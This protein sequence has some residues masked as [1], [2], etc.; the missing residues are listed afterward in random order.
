MENH[1]VFPFIYIDFSVNS[2]LYSGYIVIDLPPPKKKINDN[3]SF[4]K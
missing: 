4:M 1:V 3:R 2:P